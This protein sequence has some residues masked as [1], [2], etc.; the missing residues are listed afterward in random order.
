MSERAQ[1]SSL[2]RMLSLLA[3]FGHIADRRERALLAPKRPRRLGTSSSRRLRQLRQAQRRVALS[4]T[5]GRLEV[6]I[7]G[8]FVARDA[9]E[10]ALELL[11]LADD[12]DAGADPHA[13][14]ARLL[15]GQGGR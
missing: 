2:E 15:S 3:S 6:S 7:E 4:T 13:T 8:G 9:V 10:A 14:L 5:G 12:V 1:I 11:V